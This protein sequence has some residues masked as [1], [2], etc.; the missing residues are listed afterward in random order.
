MINSELEFKLEEVLQKFSANLQEKIQHSVELLRKSER[1]ALAYDSEAGFYLAFSGGKDSQCL[2][3]IARLAG[4]KF[5]AHMSLTS[6]DPPEVIRFVKKQYPDIN[7]VKPKK[8][9]YQAAI[10]NKILPTIRARWCC[11]EYK[12][13]AGAGKAKEA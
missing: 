13:G 9:I 12:E 7:L 11:K 5:K 3:H 10:D 8:S 2:Y 4:V 1:L 6:V